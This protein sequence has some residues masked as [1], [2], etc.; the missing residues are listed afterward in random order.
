MTGVVIAMLLNALPAAAAV[1]C[2]LEYRAVLDT[3]PPQRQWLVQRAWAG[4]ATGRAE[5][6][7]ALVAEVRSVLR[8]QNLPRDRRDREMFTL[9]R[10]VAAAEPVT[11]V[12]LA[13][14]TIAGPKR[15]PMAGVQIAI[16]GQIVGLTDGTGSIDL[17]ATPRVHVLTAAEG[18]S[19][20]I[21]VLADLSDG[22]PL[23][24][25]LD[26]SRNHGG[27]DGGTYAYHLRELTS[28]C[29]PF[30]IEHRRQYA[31][32][33]L[34][35]IERAVV[36]TPEAAVGVH[37]L[38]RI[39]AERSAVEPAACNELFGRL[40]T[41]AP[42]QVLYVEAVDTSGARYETRI[43]VRSGPNELRVSLRWP[44][45]QR[46]PGETVFVRQA[47]T[48]QQM[49]YATTDG[50]GVA[51][52]GQLPAGDYLLASDSLGVYARERVR[53]EGN[54]S[55]DLY[56]VPRP[57]SGCVRESTAPA[58]PAVCEGDREVHL[59]FFGFDAAE[60]LVPRRYW[61]VRRGDLER[62]RVS[63]SRIA[64][65]RI[66]NAFPFGEQFAKYIEAEMIDSKGRPAFRTLGRV[67]LALEAPGG[68]W[69]SIAP[70]E[71]YFTL[72]LPAG[73]SRELRLRGWAPQMEKTFDL[74]ALA[75]ELS[76]VAAS[77]GSALP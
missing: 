10:C 13:V 42:P 43:D 41:L 8:N 5:T 67:Q 63:Q 2:E 46:V 4:Y 36:V 19:A 25:D 73:Y 16:D 74:R 61:R 12:P 76:P 35:R 52:F 28:A 32:A 77:T 34:Q 51:V 49:F 15:E 7:D 22:K 3:V 14:R 71:R 37:D 58:A 54:R 57:S 62:H 72:E 30:R 38:F 48:D 9:L 66:T 23:S 1:P 45:G 24:V 21:S 64:R 18:W 59:L 6:S 75:G 70:Q 29:Q 11:V 44:A 50:E 53:V 47:G 60:N 26:L 65:A 17:V 39:S 56:L 68:P 20:P 27:G 55:A 33:S 31:Q 40:S 69:F